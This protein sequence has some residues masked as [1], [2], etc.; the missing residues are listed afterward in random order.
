MLWSCEQWFH[1]K[2]FVGIV[3]WFFHHIAFLTLPSNPSTVNNNFLGNIGI[4]DCSSK[5]NPLSSNANCCAV[6]LVLFW[7]LYH[8]AFRLRR[9]ITFATNLHQL[10]FAISKEW[11]HRNRKRRK[12]QPYHRHKRIFS[13][14]LLGTKMLLEYIKYYINLVEMGTFSICYVFMDHTHARM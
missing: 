10:L 11:N 4:Q 2:C 14:Q 1:L 6:C 8:P 12:S 9:Y 13:W 3:A 5:A 7:N